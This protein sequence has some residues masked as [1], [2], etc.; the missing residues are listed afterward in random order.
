MISDEQV[1]IALAVWFQDEGCTPGPATMRDMRAAL[2]AAS[3]TGP[4]PAMDDVTAPSTGG[5]AIYNMTLRHPVHGTF[6]V[7]PGHG[8]GNILASHCYLPKG[9]TE[10]VNNDLGKFATLEAAQAAVARHIAELDAALAEP[11][12]VAEVAQ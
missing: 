1:R 10:A 6:W 2:E 8:A 5:W 7:Y 4:W 12:Q 3:A 11:A 9:A